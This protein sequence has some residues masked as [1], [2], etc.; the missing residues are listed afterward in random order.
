MS[1]RKTALGLSATGREW[2]Q[3]CSRKGLAIDQG[4]HMAKQ[5][6]GGCV[7][8]EKYVVAHS[9]LCHDIHQQ[10]IN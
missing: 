1:R 8:T 3:A 4:I 2:T 6:L 5:N 9:I 7:A 10:T